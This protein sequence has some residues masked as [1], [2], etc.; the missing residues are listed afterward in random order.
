MRQ[1]KLN[2]QLQ[3][4][5]KS[6]TKYIYIYMSPAFDLSIHPRNSYTGFERPILIFAKER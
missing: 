5:R 3:N 1:G 6:Y 2:Y 4:I